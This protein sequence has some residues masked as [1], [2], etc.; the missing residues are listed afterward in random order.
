MFF[1]EACLRVGLDPAEMNSKPRA[2]F[3]SKSLTPEMLD[4]KYDTFERKR[5]DKIA[6]VKKE[7]ISLIQ[8]SE[9]NK[10]KATGGSPSKMESTNLSNTNGEE[11]G[12]SAMMRMEQIRMEALRRRQEKEL[13]KIVEKEQ[14][15]VSLQKKMQRTEE[16]ELKKKKVHEKKV[17]EQKAAAEKKIIQ[18]QL[19]IRRREDD[20]AANKRELMKKEKE[21]QEK[22]RIKARADEIALG[23]EARERDAERSLK[24]QQYRE[25]TD[26]LLAQQ[27]AAAEKSR[28]IMLE[29]EQRVQQQLQEKIE[30]KHQEVAEAREKAS[31]R[32]DEA[33]EK[34]HSIHEQKK[35]DFDARQAEAVVRAKENEVIEREKYKKQADTREKR[36]KIRYNRLLDA[37][38]NR[39]HHRQSIIERR[40][41]KDKTFLVVQ[42]ETL[43]KTSM[44]KFSTELKL[45]DKLE[46]VE[47]IARVQEFKR[48]QTLKKIQES[49]ARY[50]KIQAG[51]QDLLLK[52][53]EETK[54][55]LCRKHEISDAMESMRISN[56]FGMLDKLFAKKQG[57]TGGKGKTADLEETDDPR[58]N[59]TA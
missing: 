9:K 39:A 55:S 44:L 29:R 8:F 23:K 22:Q 31:K 19:E 42:E 10:L 30:L 1:I 52:R 18:R 51:K 7:R 17:K 59:Q 41:E 21:F 47:R 54:N 15:A 48:L 45:N 38:T 58:Q 3:K 43:K 6:A 27:A 12:E 33:L 53:L 57:K 28:L 25:K 35:K 40:N 46:N 32:I 26:A 24:I 14:I 20:E 49:D 16:E 34:H 4:I 56:D 37:F 36:V 50:D 13:S 5:K 11:P 2:A